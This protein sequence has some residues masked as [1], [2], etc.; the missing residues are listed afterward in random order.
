MTAKERYYKKVYDAA[1]DIE[2]Q[3]GCG[4]LIKSKDKYGRNKSFVNGHNL[5]SIASLLGRY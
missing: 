1:P 2:C 4:I 5:S 3:C